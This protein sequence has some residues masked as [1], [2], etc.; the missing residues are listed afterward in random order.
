MLPISWS[1]RPSVAWSF[2]IGADRADDRDLQPIQHP[3]D[4]EGDDDQQVKAAP[5]QAVHPRRDVGGDF[6]RAHSLLRS[7]QRNSA[8]QRRRLH[9]RGIVVR[10]AGLSSPSAPLRFRS[11]SCSAIGWA[12][13]PHHIDT[14]AKLFEAP[15]GGQGASQALR[16]LDLTASGR[17]G[18]FS[19]ASTK[20]V[21]T[22]DR[23]ED[24]WRNEPRLYKLA[25]PK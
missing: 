23:S 5:G 20:R 10:V 12:R 1:V 21:L 16:R 22:H 19:V 11:A 13:I 7:M 8:A 15:G 4:A 18:R 9:A 25:A 3:G 2:R 14:G 6:A 24:C 17:S